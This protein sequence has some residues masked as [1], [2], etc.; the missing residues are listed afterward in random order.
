[1]RILLL[2]AALPL[3]SCAPSL[4]DDQVPAEVRSWLRSEFNS[5]SLP[6]LAYWPVEHSPDQVCG[7]VEA[8]PELRPYRQ[9]VRYTYTLNSKRNYRGSVEPHEMIRVSGP[10]GGD[11]LE[12]GR[13]VFDSYWSAHCEPAAP[14]QLKLAGWFGQRSPSLSDGSVDTPLTNGYAERAIADAD[15]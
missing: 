10:L 11:V 8:P 4:A 2:A 15:L 12:E 3:A 6:H 9:T 1:M 14:M 5:R 7:E 13:R